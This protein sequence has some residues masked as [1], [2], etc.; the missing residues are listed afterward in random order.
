[1]TEDF[2]N[3]EQRNALERA[4]CR[5][6]KQPNDRDENAHALYSAGKLKGF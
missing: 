5:R 3:I 2:C 4:N 6:K 1:M